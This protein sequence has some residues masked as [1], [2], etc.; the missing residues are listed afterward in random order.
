MA[1]LT[2][3]NIPAALWILLSG[4]FGTVWK[5]DDIIVSEIFFPFPEAT[6]LPSMLFTFY[7]YS[8]LNLVATS[9]SSLTTTLYK[10][11]YHLLK[12]YRRKSCVSPW[13]AP[14]SPPLDTPLS[15][16][17]ISRDLTISSLTCIRQTIVEIVTWT[18]LLAVIL[19]PFC[20]D[21]MWLRIL[22][23]STGMI[24]FK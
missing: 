5:T 11:C 9:S 1:F 2:L 10:P 24:L 22:F 15:R 6:A 19:L 23:R 8:C 18:L 14:F 16:V 4:M 17:N 12:W 21:C 20:G 3:Y 13:R 7:L